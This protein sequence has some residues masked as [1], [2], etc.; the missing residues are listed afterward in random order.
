MLLSGLSDSPPASFVVAG[1]PGQGKTRLAVDVARELARSGSQIVGVTGTRAMRDVPFGAFAPVVPEVSDAASIAN[2]LHLAACALADRARREQ[3]LLVIDDA[4]Y[5]DDGSAALL[6]HLAQT[7]ACP[8]L[9]TLRTPFDSPDPVTTLWKDDYARRIDLAPL[10]PAELEEVIVEELGGPVAAATL[11]WLI[12][13]SQ[14]N[15]LY[16][17]EVLLAADHSGA[18]VQRDGLWLIRHPFPPSPRL[19]DLIGYRLADLSEGATRVVDLLAL[20]EPLPFDLLISAAD[21][22]SVDE[23][24]RQGI[25]VRRASAKSWAMLGHPLFGEVRR[26]QVG[27]VRQRALSRV[28]IESFPRSSDPTGDE[29]VRLATWQLDGGGPIEPKLMADAAAYARRMYDLDLAVKLAT[30]AIEAGAAVDAALNLAE[31]LYMNQRPDEAIEI[32]ETAARAATSQA[33]VAAAAAAS[34]HVLGTM[35]GDRAAAEAVLEEAFRQVDDPDLQLILLD[36]RNTFPL[37]AGEPTNT[38]PDALLLMESADASVANRA[39][40][41]VSISYALLGQGAKAVEIG[42]RG[43]A[44]RRAGGIPHRRDFLQ[45]M[46][47]LLAH[48]AA[49]R[50]V[51]AEELARRAMDPANDQI[52]DVIATYEHLLGMVLLD[53]GRAHA[54]ERPLRDALTFNREHADPGPLR[55]CLGGLVLAHAHTGELE[56]ARAAMDELDAFGPTW[57]TMF[58]LDLN[59]R[60][61]AWLAVQE[62]DEIRGRKLLEA[63][64]SAARGRDSAFT[65]AVLLHDLVRLGEPDIA[66][67]RLQALAEVVEGPLVG[68]FAEHATALAS[69]DCAGLE[70]AATRFED[71]GALLLAAEVL[72]QVA[73]LGLDLDEPSARVPFLRRAQV[74]TRRCG[75]IRTPAL[76]LG[77]NLP[78]LTRR[79]EQVA[80]LAV[81]GV[82]SREIAEQ[83]V[84]SIRTVENHLQSAYDKLGA[85]SRTEL[86]E[87]GD[88]LGH[89]DEI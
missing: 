48:R 10:S 12:E 7:R 11:R 55:W 79:E 36:A 44:I 82:S 89:A 71:F 83:L 56:M 27:E 34:S 51:E 62:G 53:Q 86:V 81:D 39:A 46:G 13:N 47:T 41:N 45:H 20:G 43:L 42:R 65:E 57:M 8:V 84:L 72:H 75:P 29:L 15:P 16:T 40:L 80:R 1:P 69:G 6:L 18:L 35:M 25:V 66:V 5:L 26:Q 67:D 49:G 3:I 58:D 74:L 33:D 88:G 63:A 2:A 17:R 50:L 30:A 78:R 23:A 85:R 87:L 77:G 70:M 73:G 59:E 31:A 68:V 24:E 37:F 9:V 28:L 61:R 32:L 14:G 22:E 60:G 38:L 21:Q 54:A 4:Q 19:S 76:F 64:A 52:G